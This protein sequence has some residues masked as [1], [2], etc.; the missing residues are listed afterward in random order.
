L[1]TCASPALDSSLFPTASAH[2]HPSL[3]LFNSEKEITQGL[4]SVW[5]HRQLEGLALLF[6]LKFGK[7]KKRDLLSSCYETSY[8]WSCAVHKMPL[9]SSFDT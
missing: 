1:L 8:F 5:D 6:T 2:M 9:C 4:F 3:Y 7:V